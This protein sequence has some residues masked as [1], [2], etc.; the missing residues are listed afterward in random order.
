VKTVRV[1]VR[2]DGSEFTIRLWGGRQHWDWG[3]SSPHFGDAKNQ[4]LKR[5]GHILERPDP[6]G[7]DDSLEEELIH[8]LKAVLA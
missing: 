6:G 3:E 2:P 1:H 5:G 7:W 8:R 4:I